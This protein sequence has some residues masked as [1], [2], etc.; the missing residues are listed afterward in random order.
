MALT[1]I[2]VDPSIAADSGAGTIGD[3]YGDLEYAI[4]QETFDTTNGTRVNIKAGTD[5]II[6]ANLET[7]L[8]DTSVSAAW[9]PS[10][11]APLVIQGYTSAAGDGGIG[12][13]SGGGAALSI[14]NTTRDFIWL[15]DLHLHNVTGANR[16][17]DL[18]SYST[19]LRCEINN[20]ADTGVVIG[21]NCVIQSCY[22]HDVGA[23][24]RHG[25]QASGNNRIAFNYIDCGEGTD[26]GQYGIFAI[27]TSCSIE[28]N[29]I[30]AAPSY[31]GI[32]IASNGS[33]VNNNSIFAVAGTAAG[34]NLSANSYVPTVMNNLVEGFSGVGGIGI[35]F[36]ASTTVGV[37]DGN[38]AYNC[39]TDFDTGT[40]DVL[41][42]NGAGNESLSASPFTNAAA[43]NFSPVDTGSVK[44]G[45]IPQIIGGGFV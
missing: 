21:S 2:Y 22:I 39:T 18:D 12:G 31:Y 8:A 43:G 10:E 27:G 44:E 9:V 42:E 34:I 3:P 40:I 23:N 26:K 36:S 35:V 19:I 6:A 38:A 5:E 11:D 30:I 15:I 29:I 33:M 1:E 7:A 14:L 28:N 45:S 41:I 4:E 13:I 20:G 16:I 24:N 17:I 32:G 37:L 25:I